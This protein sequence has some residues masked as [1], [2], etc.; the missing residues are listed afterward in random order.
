MLI[1]GILLI[2]EGKVMKLG[3]DYSIQ[4]SFLLPDK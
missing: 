1:H 2:K 3:R 4:Q